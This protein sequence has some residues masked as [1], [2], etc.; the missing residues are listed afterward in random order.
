MEVSIMDKKTPNKDEINQN[1]LNKFAN[2]YGADLDEQAMNG[3][4]GMLETEEED[5]ANKKGKK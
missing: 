1:N 3:D 4:Y 2:E 5:R